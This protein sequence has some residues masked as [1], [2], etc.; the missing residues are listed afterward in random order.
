MPPEDTGQPLAAPETQDPK[1]AAAD[2]FRNYEPEAG[3]REL[4][5]RAPDGKFAKATEEIE[6]EAEPETV[7]AEA[8]SQ[9][10]GE[11]E[12]EA[13][14]EAQPEELILPESWP[15]DKA[16][17]WNTL[18]PDA[19][20]YIRQRDAEQK[21]AIN[22]KF[23]ETANARKAAEA[24]IA[25]AQANRA[26]ALAVLDTAIAVLQPQAPPLSM[27]DINSSDY[28]P[29]SYHYQKAQAES[30][31]QYVQSLLVQRQQLTAQE[32]QEA[33]NAVQQQDAEINE[34]LGPAFM[35]EYPESVDPQKAQGFFADLIKFGVEAGL[36]AEMFRQSQPN[37][38]EWQLL[39][40]AKKWRA[41]KA[42]LEKAR[43][44]KP[45]PKKAQPVVRPGVTT[46]RSAIEATKQRSDMERLDRTGRYQDAAPI[47]KRLMKG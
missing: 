14:D 2:A 5:P 28:D 43:Q 27:L 38:A 10:E 47:F 33:L 9:V 25:E 46:P 6:A 34:K 32:Q 24:Q 11:Q 44:G 26:N 13:A 36:P 39:A 35:A 15:A 18:E 31:A 1:A 8:E 16:E 42:A 41:H 21:A 7:E 22:A 20:A 29:D 12:P 30:Q 40:D 3:A 45:E 19:Q 37:I 4:P 23:M 17:L